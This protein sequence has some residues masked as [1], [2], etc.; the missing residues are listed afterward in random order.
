[1]RPAG[2]G[3]GTGAELGLVAGCAPSGP[4]IRSSA[5]AASTI[6]SPP[7]ELPRVLGG[8]HTDMGAHHYDMPVGLDMDNSGPVEYCPPRIRPAERAPATV[9]RTAIELVHGGPDGCM[10]HGTEGTLHITRG[11]LKSD[12]SNWRKSRCATTKCTCS[13][14]PDT[15]AIGS[16]ASKRANVASPPSRR[17]RTVTIVTSATSPTGTVAGSMGSAKLVLRRRRRGQREVPRSRAS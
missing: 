5:R 16:T 6:T 15:I 2:R 14:L 1:V 12:P 13:H 10:F 7:G 3:A 17:G 8:G 11:V 9:T 4:T